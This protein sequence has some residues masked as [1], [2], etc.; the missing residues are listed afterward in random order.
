MDP[1]EKEEIPV[2]EVNLDHKDSLDPEESLAFQVSQ[3]KVLMEARERPASPGVPEPRAS[4]E[5]CWEPRLAARGGT[6]YRDFLE[7][8]ASL[9]HRGDLDHPVLTAAQAFLEERESAAL[10]V[11]PV[12]PGPPDLPVNPTAAPLVESDPL[13]ARD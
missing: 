3:D 11:F 7:T 9:G 12:S 1:K 6:A 2:P 8:K 5:T 13:A 10:T 4:P